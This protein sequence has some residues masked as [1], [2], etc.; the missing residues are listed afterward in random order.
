MIT[1]YYV[2]LSLL[3]TSQFQPCLATTINRRLDNG[4]GKTPAMGWNNWNMGGGSSKSFFFHRP[5][6][7]PS[8]PST[9]PQP[10]LLLIHIQP[11]STAAY[12]LA[13]AR[14]FISLGLDK[15]GY[16]YVNIDDCWSTMS[17]DS[18]GNLV[19]DPNKWPN[20]IKNV[21]D[22]IHSMGLKFGMLFILSNSVLIVLEREDRMIIVCVCNRTLRRLRNSNMFRLPRF[23]RS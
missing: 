13:A 9:P 1:P 16:Q 14:L 7:S 6:S 11:A 22:Q 8:L 19:A 3:A 18:T 10:T 20:G 17:R 15:V 2:F 4:I 21:S 23:T 5:P 12:A